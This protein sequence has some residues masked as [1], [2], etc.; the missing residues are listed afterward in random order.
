MTVQE[1]QRMTAL[2]RANEVRTSRAQL[3]R[4]IASGARSLADLLLAP[5]AVIEGVEIID[6]LQ[7]LPR[8]G[9]VK[10]KQMLAANVIGPATAIRS[11]SPARRATLAEMIRQIERRRWAA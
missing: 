4:E 10:A 9:K 11:L 8:V 7:W 6:A 3:K 2:A 5:P 1:A